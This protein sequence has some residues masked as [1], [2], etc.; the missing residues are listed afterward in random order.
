MKI[1][2]PAF[3]CAVGDCHGAL[4]A[5]YRIVE[6]IEKKA[7]READLVVQTGDLGV[8]PDPSHLDRATAK[9][10]QPGEFEQWL[11]E[12]RPVPRPTIFIAGNHEDFTFLGRLK[13]GTIVANLTFLAW[14][15]TI[16]VD[17]GGWGLRI[18]G[19]GGCYGPTDYHLRH[20]SGR[21]RRHYTEAELRRVAD[22]AKAGSRID[23]LLMH[24]APAGRVINTG[25]NRDHRKQ[26][27]S[28]SAGLEELVKAVKPRLCLT[29]HLHMCSDRLVAGVRTVGLNMIPHPG[30]VLM[31]EFQPGTSE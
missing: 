16:T 28:R 6:E 11:R 7:G 18:A 8:W 10:D 31:L 21:Q 22:E 5:M 12:Q 19:V 9:H 3:V 25:V 27:T 14:G 23:I 15:D 30:S 24:D 2:K 20:V 1:E 13:T 26:V 17:V 29:G 4:T